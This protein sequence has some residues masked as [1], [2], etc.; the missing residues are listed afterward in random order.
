MS[1]ACVTSCP[2]T[3]HHASLLVNK[4]WSITLTLWQCAG[5]LEAFCSFQNN[6][7]TNF[8]SGTTEIRLMQNC[9]K[10]SILML[11]E[12]HKSC[13]G[14]IGFMEMNLSTEQIVLLWKRF[15]ES[16]W[17]EN[18]VLTAS[19]TS[20][21]TWNNGPYD[22]EYKHFNTTAQYITVIGCS[23]QFSGEN[24]RCWNTITKEALEPVFKAIHSKHSGDKRTQKPWTN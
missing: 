13:W 14:F 17:T 19:P 10:Q 2:R 6:R 20:L 21:M 7:K 22:L 12:C 9:N 3:S 8:Q 15:C 4:M 5:F 23:R 24:E 16:A 18:N 11:F 1:P